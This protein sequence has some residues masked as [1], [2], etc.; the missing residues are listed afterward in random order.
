MGDAAALCDPI[1]GEG[2][3]YAL[4]SAALLADTLLTSGSCARYPAL[5]L[6]DFGRD[7]LK[8]AALHQ[9]FYAPGSRRMIRYAALSLAVRRVL[10]ELV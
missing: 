10:G 2:I 5:A 6:E 3:Y 4:R 7:L 9:R 1:T 8:A